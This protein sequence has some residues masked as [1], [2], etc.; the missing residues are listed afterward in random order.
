[1]EPI[2]TDQAPGAIGPYSQAV[3]VGDFLFASGQIPL[4]AGG[5]QISGS[6]AEQAAQC[7]DNVEAIL[8]AAGLGLADVMK[9]TV[10]LTDM[11][12]FASVNEVYGSRFSEPCPA[13][14]AVAV[15]ALPK[16][17]NVEIEV[18]AHAG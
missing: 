2:S 17:V 10:Y 7:L 12:D 3:R 1:M 13:R 9:T 6:A 14:S 16:G 4:T 11:D 18:I 15:A 5:D 8:K